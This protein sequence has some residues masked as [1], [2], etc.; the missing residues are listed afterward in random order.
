MKP[1]YI[2]Y[3]QDSDSKTHTHWCKFCKIST[4]IINGKLENHE[5]RCEYRLQKETELH[6]QMMSGQTAQMVGSVV[7]SD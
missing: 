6:K 2:D 3:P 4:T 7:D 5:P 1:F